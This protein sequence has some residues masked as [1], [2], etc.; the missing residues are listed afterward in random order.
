MDIKLKNLCAELLK[1][2]SSE[3]ADYLLKTYPLTNDMW[4]EALIV[5]PHRSWKREDQIR[6]I[7]HFFSQLPFA[8]PAPYKAF[9]SF[10]SIS[11][12]LSEIRN[13][14]PQKK[15]QLE[16]LTYHLEPV[17]SYFAK[18]AKDKQAVLAFLAELKEKSKT[19]LQ[20]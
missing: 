20:K 17:L 11:V 13:L 5:L 19:V 18:T 16:L 12:F 3:A 1:K 14:L 8:S 6:L 9:L 15:E 7:R 4:W 2:P 10:M